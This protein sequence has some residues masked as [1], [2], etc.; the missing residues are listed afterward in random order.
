MLKNNCSTARPPSRLQTRRSIV[1]QTLPAHPQDSGS[2]DADALIEK[3]ATAL[4]ATT[5]VLGQTLPAHLQRSLGPEAHA[6]AERIAA[7]LGLTPAPVAF[8]RTTGVL[9]EWGRWQDVQRLFGIRRGTLYALKAEGKIRSARVHGC[10]LFDLA[11][12][13][14]YVNAQLQ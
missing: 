9:P 4:G 14:A 1:G 2:G 13:R 11:S 5:D 3:I 7:A 12:V 10:R 6:L 8:D